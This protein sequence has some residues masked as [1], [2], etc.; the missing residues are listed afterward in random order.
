MIALEQQS[1]HSLHTA[2]VR[3]YVRMHVVCMYI[4]THIEIRLHRRCCYLLFKHAI[5]TRTTKMSPHLTLNYTKVTTPAGVSAA[6]TTLGN[7]LTGQH[8][9][10][11][12]SHHTHQ[13]TQQL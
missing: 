9:M 3:M 10:A 12:R 1:Q 7:S 5:G 8:P 6:G 13:D 4:H 2:H 11:D